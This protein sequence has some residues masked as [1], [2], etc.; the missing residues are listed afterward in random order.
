MTTITLDV[1]DELAVRLN[2]VRD[3]LTDLISHALESWGPGQSAAELRLSG[4]YP[5]VDEM[6]DFLANGPTPKQ[7]IA[8]KASPALQVRLEDLLD[9]NREAGLT[10][11]EKTEME[12]FRQVNHVMILLKARAMQTL[13]A[14]SP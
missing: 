7:I 14:A 6:I 4:S 1:P 12:A 5:I 8:H 2:L 9:K 10:E 13:Q 11:E 3:R